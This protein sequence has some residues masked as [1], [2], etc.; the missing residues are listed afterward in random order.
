MAASWRVFEPKEHPCCSSF[1]KT[2]TH[3]IVARTLTSDFQEIIVSD[4]KSPI[5]EAKLPNAT[6]KIVAGLKRT[7]TKKLEY[8]LIKNFYFLILGLSTMIGSPSILLAQQT[9]YKQTNLVANVAGVA[10]HT[11]AQLTNPWGISF[12]PGSPFWIANNHSGTST[13]YDAQGNKQQLVVTIPSASV[14]PCS[15]GCPTG[16]V[17]NSSTDF[18][19][20]AFIFDT[21]DGIIANWTG[22][23]SAL[24]AFDNSA[25]G[26]DYKGLALLNSGSGNFLLAANFNSGKVDVFDRNFNLTSLSGSFTDPNLPAGFAPH[27][28]HIINNQVYVAYAMQDPTKRRPVRGAGSG[29]VDIFDVN[30]NFLKT[31]ASGG[32]LNAPWGVVATPAT[33]GTFSNAILVGNFGDGTIDAFDTTGKFLGQVTD[34]GNNAIVNPG[35]WDMVFGA[36]GTGDPN[37]LYFT[38]GGPTL[39]SGLFATLVPATATTTAD[40]ALSLSPQSAT[41]SPG[42]SAM[43]SIKASETGGFSGVISLTCASPPAGVTCSFSPATIT[44]G[45]SAS[46]ST[47]TL[48]AASVAPPGGYGG[49]MM[50]FLQFSG[51]GLFGIVFAVRRRDRKPIATTQ[52]PGIW[53]SMLGLLVLGVLFTVGCGGG[54]SSTTPAAKAVTVMVTGTSGAISHTT[55]VTLTIN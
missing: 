46:A 14:S 6:Q 44:P 51:F 9:G 43:I 37:T 31:F 21:D 23:N 30:G 45:S 18:N 40:F 2:C 29:V 36:G 22:A 17:A 26:A 41:V 54:S 16:T 13:L 52:K 28:I 33:F 27:G 25:S 5:L 38:A 15:P 3:A 35:L 8:P 1:S 24:V 48:T 20:G 50:G 53:V 34:S 39:T 7:S 19:G 11:D 32:Q 12:S 10:N 49:G 47:L 55:P 42:Q 4:Q